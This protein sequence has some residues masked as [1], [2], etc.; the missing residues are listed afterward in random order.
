MQL[1]FF[2]DTI[3]LCCLVGKRRLDQALA[4]RPGLD[5]QISWL[6]FQLDPTMPVEG[7]DRKE[8][9]TERFGSVA[10]AME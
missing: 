6:P 2:S 3:F 10:A 8:H 4:E 1:D 9:L 7:I 5:I